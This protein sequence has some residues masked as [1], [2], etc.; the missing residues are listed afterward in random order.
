MFGSLR[1]SLAAVAAVALAAA[2]STAAP[3]PADGKNVTFPYPAKVPLV[4]H[5]NGLERTKDRLGKMLEALPPAEAKQVKEQIEAGLKH[6]LTDRSLSAVPADGRAFVVFHDFS[7]L[8]GEDEPA[9]SVLVPVTGYKEFKESF[10]TG[11]ERKT[12]GKAGDG[13]ESIKSSATGDETTVY[14]VDLK[15]YVAITPSK[16]TAQ[17]YAGK[18]TRAESSTMGADLAASY[19]AADIALAVNLDV[20][21]DKYGDQIR[22]FKGLID[23]ALGQAQGMGMV[24]GLNKKQ[25]ELAKVVING[26]VQA[27]EDAQGLVIAGEFRPEGLNLRG[28]I[29]FAPNT[30][31]SNMLKTEAPTALANLDKLPRG[32]TTYS[33]SKFGKKFS[34]LARQFA[35]EFGASDDDEKG[36]QQIEKL[37]AEIAAAGPEGEFGANSMPDV[38]LTIMSY[39]SPAKA[40]VALTKLYQAMAAGGAVREPRPEGQAQGDRRRPKIPRVHPERGAAVVRLRGDGRSPAGGSARDHN[41]L[42]QEGDEGEA[43]FLAG[44]G[45]QGYRPAL[46]QGLGCGQEGSRRIPGW[47]DHRRQRKWLP[48]GPQELTDRG[49]V[50][51]P[52]RNEPD[53][54]RAHRASEGCRRCDPGGSD[55]GN[56]HPESGEGPPDLRGDSDHL[57]A[58]GG[59]RRWV[60]PGRCDECRD[61]GAPPPLRPR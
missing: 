47:E 23:F 48:G 56:R 37:L 52:D 11:A 28:Q 5:V 18:Y 50:G 30:P 42:A 38:G 54:D 55:A 3:A 7:R 51:H 35:Q 44:D 26:F 32:L 36:A 29:Q 17:E 2:P 24:P 22:Q 45:W 46:G 41:R 59:N 61:P 15:G 4:I 20:I 27:I 49:D 31:S 16:D 25:L 57:E 19:L 53:V 10:L 39:K 58:T 13:V 12:A 8:V 34:D 6:L 21:N 43:G 60:F 33:G 40:V 14:L 1:L 9:V